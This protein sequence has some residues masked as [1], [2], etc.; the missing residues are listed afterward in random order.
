MHINFL[1]SFFVTCRY[2]A[3]NFHELSP[4]LVGLREV[5]DDACVH[6]VR[7]LSASSKWY[8][9]SVVFMYR[10]LRVGI[11]FCRLGSC[12]KE[13]YWAVDLLKVSFCMHCNVYDMTIY[14]Q[15]GSTQLVMTTLQ[16]LKLASFYA[17]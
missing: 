8:V 17:G 10:K 15:R 5:E 14:T 9:C 6:I 2:V 1:T 12:L 11:L 13:M 3:S 4:L 7:G 16:L